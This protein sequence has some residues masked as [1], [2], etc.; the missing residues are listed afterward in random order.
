MVA[1]LKIEK[2]NGSGQN[3]PE[4]RDTVNIPHSGR[5]TNRGM[6]AGFLDRNEPFAFALAQDRS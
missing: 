4:K 2:P 1:E 5:L 6:L 3:A